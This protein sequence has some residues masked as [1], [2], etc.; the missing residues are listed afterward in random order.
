[1]PMPTA[2]LVFANMCLSP[3]II[4]VTSHTIHEHIVRAL[5]LWGVI[6]HYLPQ[7]NYS[8]HQVLLAFPNRDHLQHCIR[9]KLP[10]RKSQFYTRQEV[11]YDW[12][13]LMQAL[14]MVLE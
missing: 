11:Q 10:H 14:Y 3:S 9:M 6:R 12:D 13:T 5:L 4:K 1:M 7:L 8:I 2:L